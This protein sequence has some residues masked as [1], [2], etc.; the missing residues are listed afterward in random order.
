MAAGEEGEVLG[1][2]VAHPHMELGL[3]DRGGVD[4]CA[5]AAQRPEVLAR[6]SARGAPSGHTAARGAAARGGQGKGCAV[7]LAVAAD[8]GELPG[9][10]VEGGGGH[11]VAVPT[12]DS[13]STN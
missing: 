7:L 1:D 3:V 9:G 13:Q 12:G 5:R 2:E 8:E 10:G 6:A 11:E 4:D